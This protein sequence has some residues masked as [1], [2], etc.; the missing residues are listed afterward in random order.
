[1]V[2][3]SAETVRWLARKGVRWRLM[4]DRQSFE[5]DG[6]LRYFGGLVLGTVDG[7]KGLIGQHLASAR[8]HGIEVRCSFAVEGLQRGESGSVTG[9]RGK[10]QGGPETVEAGAVVLAC[11]GVESQDALAVPRGGLGGGQGTRDA[12]QHGRGAQDGVGGGC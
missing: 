4:Y 6:K 2:E 10:G 3:D 8:S 11:G 12:V 5:V 1:M 7:G 9:V